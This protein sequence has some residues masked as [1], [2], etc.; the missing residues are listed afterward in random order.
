MVS[1]SGRMENFKPGNVIL[2]DKAFLMRDIPPQGISVKIPSFDHHE[3]L[4]ASEIKA[5]RNIATTRVH[6]EWAK[7]LTY[8]KDKQQFITFEPQPEYLWYFCLII[9]KCLIN[10]QTFS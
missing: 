6:I 2:A 10:N 3:R 4:T 9:D 5:S 8:D 1:A 7:A